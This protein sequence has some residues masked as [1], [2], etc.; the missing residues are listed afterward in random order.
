[1]RTYFALPA[2]GALVLRQRL[3][4]DDLRIGSPGGLSPVYALPLATDC[5]MSDNW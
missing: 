4:A 5:S 1:M 3:V 2:A